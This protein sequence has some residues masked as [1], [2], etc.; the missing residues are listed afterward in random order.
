MGS[1]S[2]FE[3]MMYEYSVKARVNEEEKKYLLNLLNSISDLPLY[4]RN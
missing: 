3:F 4:D 2:R 1:V